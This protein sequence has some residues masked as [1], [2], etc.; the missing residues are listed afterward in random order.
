MVTIM[1]IFIYLLIWIVPQRV[2]ANEMLT[3]KPS[4]L[5]RS[6]DSLTILSS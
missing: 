2:A 5:I 3:D 1:H 6:L 4:F